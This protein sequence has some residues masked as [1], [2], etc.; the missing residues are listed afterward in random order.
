MKN[1]TFRKKALLS[2]VAML[3]VALVALGSATFAWFSANPTVTATG[4]SVKSSAA[5]GLKIAKTA[6]NGTKPD[7]TAFS[8]TVTI[9]DMNVEGKN[10]WAPVSPILAEGDFTMYAGASDSDTTG[11]LNASGAT[12]T[13]AGFYCYD[14][15]LLA[16]NAATTENI[17]VSATFGGQGVSYARA[18][19]IDENGNAYYLSSGS[20]TFNKLQVLE[21]ASVATASTTAQTS[22]SS[23][24][25]SCAN[26][27]IQSGARLHLYVWF[28]GQDA[29]CVDAN[30][31]AGLTL[32]LTFTKE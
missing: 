4:L 11:E 1:T 21:G 10:V 5:D 13:S 25:I 16:A 31:N 30:A 3:L 15:W 18:A 24:T 6:K 7:A 22:E 26:I 2:S 23:Q 19:L 27:S 20:D 9:D 32:S 12:P 17:N 14:L 8:Q 29:Q 28:E